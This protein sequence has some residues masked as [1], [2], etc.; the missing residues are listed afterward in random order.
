MIT[1]SGCR[2]SSESAFP[3]TTLWTGC[4]APLIPANPQYA[5][6]RCPAVYT[7]R[8]CSKVGVTK[9]GDD[10]KCL[11]RLCTSDFLA[12]LPR[13]FLRRNHKQRPIRR[14]QF[15]EQSAGCGAYSWTLSDRCFNYIWTSNANLRYA[16][17]RPGV[18]RSSRIHLHDARIRLPFMLGLLHNISYM[19][20]A[21]HS[22]SGVALRLQHM[23]AVGCHVYCDYHGVFFLDHGH[24]LKLY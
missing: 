14:R 3:E 13:R 16:A 5:A 18:F 23:I 6:S 9:K 19:S 4:S 1:R 11:A 22:L 7:T 20:N 21:C 17:A 8:F 12:P 24:L 10:A 2:S 15:D